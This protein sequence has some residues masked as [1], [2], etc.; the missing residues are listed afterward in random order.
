MIFGL[1]KNPLTKMIF[2][3]VKNKAVDDFKHKAEK[4]KT[5]REAEILACK[6]V[7]VARI[8]S[9]DK[10]WK[11]EIL[12]IWLIG[13]LSTGWF[14]STR[15]RFEEWVR[16]INDLP[17]SVWYLVIIVFTATFST[18]MTDKVLNRNKK[19]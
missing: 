7:D 2:N 12:L 15:D 5:I 16:I 10:S 17:D 11:D 3:T 13:M 6:E 14:E 19:K 8:K 4:V 1:L 18:K 9:Q